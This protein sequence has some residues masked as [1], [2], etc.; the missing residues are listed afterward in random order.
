[1]FEVIKFQIFNGSNLHN[2]IKVLLKNFLIYKNTHVTRTT[3]NFLKGET[4]LFF[5]RNPT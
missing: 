5:M 2:F 3:R 1:M 4:L